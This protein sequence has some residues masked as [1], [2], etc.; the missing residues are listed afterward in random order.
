MH[1]L[2][3]GGGGYIGSIAVERLVA[4][5]DRVTV[6]DSFV[7]GHRQAVHPDAA[8]V[9]CDIRDAVA[10]RDAVQ[11]LGA[12]AIMHFAALQLVPESVK[13]PGAY[14]ATNTSGGLHMLEAARD[15]GIQRFVFS[16]TAAVYGEPETVPIPE[17]SPKL[18]INPYGQSK[19]MVEQMLEA[20][21]RQ[22]GLNH[23]IFR[24][25]NVAGASE[26]R[27]EDHNPETHVIP[28]AL[29]ALLGQRDGFVVYGTDYDTADGTAVRDYVHVIDLVDAHIAALDRLDEPLGAMNLGTANGFSVQQIVDAVQWVT[30]R[31]L[32]VTYGARRE[33]DPA[34]LIA[35]STRAREVLDWRPAHS[36]LDEMIGSAWEW[37]QRHPEGYGS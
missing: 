32:P 3:T 27:G 4:R 16:S 23:A 29:Q 2:V 28:V 20:F 9:E 1:V 8:I 10:T 24:Y 17:N 36:T 18:P 37:L 14:F 12:E 11:R 21:A 6:L 34:T 30:G 26:Q 19:W 35:D 22:H 31:E 13:E 33:G 7:R 25:F 5:G 15:A